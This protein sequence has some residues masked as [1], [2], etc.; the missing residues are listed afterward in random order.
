[1]K[2][3]TIDTNV[4]LDLIES[5]A[6][7]SERSIRALDAAAGRGAL[8]I[9][10]TTYAELAA[11]YTRFHDETVAR[12][13]LDLFLQQSAIRVEPLTPDA[14]ATAGIAYAK[15]LGARPRSDMECPR[16][17][18]RQAFR[19]GKCGSAVEW[20][21]HIIS[22]FLIGAHALHTTGVLLTRDRHLHRKIPGLKVLAP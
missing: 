6:P 21:L 17:G 14:A 12:E 1:M 22:D 11:H 4:L 2:G 19:C 16:C 20:R 13:E 3:T 18:Q 5:G 7:E 9:G 15:H 8:V 10:P